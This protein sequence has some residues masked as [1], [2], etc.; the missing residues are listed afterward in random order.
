MPTSKRVFV[1][2]WLRSRV[3]IDRHELAGAFGDIGTDLPLLVGLVVTCKLDPAAVFVTFGLLQI[4]TGI[5]YGMP[6]PVQ[7]LKAMA[8]IMLAQ[9]LSPGVLAGGGLVIGVAMLSLA[10]TGLLNRISLL[11]PKVAVRGIQLGLGMSLATLALKDYA[12]NDGIAGYVLVAIS[13]ILLLALR[14]QRKVPAPLV[15]IALGV[16]YALIWRVNPAT[17][18]SGIGFRLPVFRLPSASDL[19]QGALLLALPQL[20]LSLG[21]SVIATSQ[22]T[23]DLFPDRPVSV[24]KIGLTYGLMNVIGPLFGGVPVCHGCGGLVGFHAFGARTGGAPV[25]YGHCTLYSD[26]SLLPASK[27]SSES[28]PCRSSALSFFLRPSRS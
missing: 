11:V 28:S 17:L 13:M 5:L 12:A 15:V 2:T 4:A 10:A 21:N 3:R 14:R 7:P 1:I 20:P 26:S 18:A 23:R 25:L 9:R 6:I 27:T 16:L 22:T 19:A 8:A 24:Q